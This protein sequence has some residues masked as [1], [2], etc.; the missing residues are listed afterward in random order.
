MPDFGGLPIGQVMLAAKRCANHNAEWT[1][2]PMRY[3]WGQPLQ[4]IHGLITAA[5]AALKGPLSRV[6][7][8]KP[9]A[10]AVAAM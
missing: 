7:T 3:A 8:V 9:L 6:A 10:A 5:P 2:H 4:P 1:I